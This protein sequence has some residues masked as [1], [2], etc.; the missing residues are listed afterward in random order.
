MIY[1][2]GFELLSHSQLPTVLNEV[3]YIYMDNV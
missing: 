2:T 3:E 1:E